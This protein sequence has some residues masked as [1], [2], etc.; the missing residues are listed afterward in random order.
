RERAIGYMQTQVGIITSERVA[1]RVV[2]ELRLAEHPRARRAYEDSGYE[3]PIEDWLAQSL[4]KR[5]K[6]TTSQSNIIH[7][8]VGAG[9]P[10]LAADIANAFARIYIDTVLA[11]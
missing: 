6:V 10:R 11:L 7:V 5:L 2:R 8:T 1:R 9:E 4:L 3:G